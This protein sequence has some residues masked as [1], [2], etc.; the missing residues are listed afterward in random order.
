MKLVMTHKED[1]VELEGKSAIAFIIEPA[2]EDGAD[3]ATL[4]M[5]T[6]NPI[7]LMMEAGKGLGFLTAQMC[8]QNNLDKALMMIGVMH[9]FKD[10]LLNE[11]E[12]E[13][14]A[15]KAKSEPVTD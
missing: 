3:L 2:D 14:K 4:C 12:D 8:E 5:G 9:S 10:G 11:S 1:K 6:D 7:H 15:E 13:V